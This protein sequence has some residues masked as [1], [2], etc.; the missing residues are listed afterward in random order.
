M[1]VE[2]RIAWRER[3][4]RGPQDRRHLMDRRFRQGGLKSGVRS[5]PEPK[6]EP[7]ALQVIECYCGLF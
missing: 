1:V 5:G 6:P 4:L 2:K 3:P 7:D